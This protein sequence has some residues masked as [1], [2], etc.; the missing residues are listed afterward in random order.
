MTDL[1]FDY[2]PV[3][4]RGGR[5]YERLYLFIRYKSA[6][7]MDAVRQ[8]HAQ[9]SARNEEVPRRRRTRKTTEPERS[10]AA[11]SVAEPLGDEL[12]T[13][14]VT[15][16]VRV[17]ESRARSQTLQEKISPELYSAVS[18]VLVYTAR[19]LTNTNS[20]KKAKQAQETRDALNRILAQQH[21]LTCW[22]LGMARM[23]LTK[24]EHGQLKSPQYNAT[25]VYNAMEDI[26]IIPSGR[27]ELRSAGA[28]DHFKAD[29]SVFD[30]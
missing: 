4:I 2:I 23:M 6:Q 18:S 21:D 8:L 14:T 22:A 29:L 7:E 27:D 5:K 16:A 12:F 11:V 19:L 13:M 10:A 3:R 1:W 25:I 20:E 30:E 17:L 26:T 15:R 24:K 28:T 9:K